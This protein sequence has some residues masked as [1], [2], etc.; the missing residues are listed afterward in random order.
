MYLAREGAETDREVVSVTAS[1]KAVGGAGLDDTPN[2][3]ELPQ[4]SS[5]EPKTLT[6][7]NQNGT[8]SGCPSSACGH[9]DTTTAGVEQAGAKSFIAVRVEHGK[10]GI[11]PLGGRRL[12]KER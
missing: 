12:C 10:P 8:Q 2:T 5:S 9:T 11:P 7:S 3:C 4:A 1:V 6:G